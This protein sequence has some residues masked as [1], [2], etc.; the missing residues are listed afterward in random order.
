M[1]TRNLILSVILIFA[2]L[3]L[4]MSCATGKK[5]YVAKENEEIYGTWVNT[6]YHT[7]EIYFLPQKIITKPDGTFEMYDGMADIAHLTYKY[8]IIGKWTDSEG[9]IWYKLITEHGGKTYGA[10]PFYEL[11]KISNSGLT[12]ERA[13]STEA[14]PTEIDPD[15]LMYFIYYRQ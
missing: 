7:S 13:S 14:Y 2:V 3:V 6:E 12:W 10:K 4:L 9:N 1:K 11:H 5:A 8:T 15:H